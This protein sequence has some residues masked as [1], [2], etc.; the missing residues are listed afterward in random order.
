M[1]EN[2]LLELAFSPLWPVRRACAPASATHTQAF[3][4][5]ANPCRTAFVEYNINSD[6][7]LVTVYG[8]GKLIQKREMV[9]TEENILD[10]FSHCRAW[11]ML[12][13]VKLN[14]K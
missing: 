12:P 13:N 2:T 9:L 7:I 1:T 14:W 6:S 10:A 4:H 11:V 5:Q 3:V 8:S